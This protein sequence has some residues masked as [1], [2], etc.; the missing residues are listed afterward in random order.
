MAG[1]WRALAGG[2]PARL[3]AI[4]Q[5]TNE[6]LRCVYASRADNPHDLGARRNCWRFWTDRV[7]P[8]FVLALDDYREDRAGLM[9]L[10]PKNRRDSGSEDVVTVV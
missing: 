6:D 7:P 2:C 10:T 9:E 1:V 5:T 4:A 8:S 3:I